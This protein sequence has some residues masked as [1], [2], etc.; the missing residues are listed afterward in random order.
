MAS[1]ITE[2]TKS[3]RKRY[4]VAFRDEHGVRKAIRLVGVSKRDAGEIASKVQAIMSA[5]ISGAPL[6]NAVAEWVAGI[7]DELHSK[8]AAAGLCQT[9]RNA[10]LTAFI[11]GLIAEWE[12]REGNAKPA[13]RTLINWK[14]ARRKLSDYFVEDPKLSALTPEQAKGWR[15][16]LT[17]MHA[18]ATVAA[19]V[20]R[21]KQFFREAVE[22]GYLQTSPFE[23]LVAG[24]DSNAERKAYVSVDDVQKLIDVAPDA[25]WR[26]MIALARYGGLRTPS[27]TLRL[28]W[29]DI[30][31]EAGVMRVTSPKTAKQGKASRVVPLFEELL[32]YLLDAREV[33]PE[34]EFCISRYRDRE[35]NLRTQMA[36]LIDRAGLQAWPRLWHALRASRATDLADR[37]PSHVGAEWLGHTEEVARRNYRTV[38]AEHLAMARGEGGVRHP[39]QDANV[40]GRRG[41][42][43]GGAQ[44]GGKRQNR[45]ASSAPPQTKNPAKLSVSRG[46]E[47][48]AVPRRGV[49]P[50]SPP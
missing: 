16:W 26:L 44:G 5:R 46:L 35:S 14:A 8:L 43:G 47:R 19:H 9:R 17:E 39:G 34:S 40:E 6:A 37:F 45:V 33:R 18:S 20:K 3:G 25:E 11:D 15:V 10:T 28:R 7:G 24:D 31:W 27:E 1:V 13:A 29:T 32:P 2:S 21:A 4:R 36:R 38:T 22:R 49:E 42:A 12:A 48:A 23:G 41:D 50:L 30:D